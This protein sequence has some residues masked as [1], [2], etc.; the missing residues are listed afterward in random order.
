MVVIRYVNGLNYAIP[1]E[2]IRL[3]FRIV[4]DSCK[5]ALKARRE[6]IEENFSEQME[7][8]CSKLEILFHQRIDQ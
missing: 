2:L 5:L 3:K 7:F 1:G 8:D 6:V 4:G